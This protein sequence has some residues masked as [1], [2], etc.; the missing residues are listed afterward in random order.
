MEWVI[1]QREHSGE[2]T[3]ILSDYSPL[4]STDILSVVGFSARSCK[5]CEL[6]RHPYCQLFRECPLDMLLWSRRLCKY[7]CCQETGRLHLIDV[8]PCTSP[9][10]WL[11]P[12]QMKEITPWLL[13]Y[14]S[15]CF[16]LLFSN[17]NIIPINKIIW[18]YAWISRAIWLTLFFCHLLSLSL[19]LS[20]IHVLG[21]VCSLLFLLLL[22]L[23]TKMLMW[24]ALI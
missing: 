17:L 16:P 11:R 6:F 8:F 22:R 2:T 4:G 20:D 12:S 24:V 9:Y 3:F 13:R 14:S 5:A 10:S 15:L 1:L 21:N 19:Y 18:F 23:C 7:Q